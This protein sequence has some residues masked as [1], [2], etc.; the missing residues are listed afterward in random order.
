MT[1]LAGI[2]VTTQVAMIGVGAKKLDK[3]HVRLGY[4]LGCDSRWSLEIKGPGTC[5]ALTLPCVNMINDT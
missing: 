5:I 2:G 4:R 3:K 1:S